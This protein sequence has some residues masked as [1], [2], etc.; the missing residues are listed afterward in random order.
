MSRT[1]CPWRSSSACI[2]PAGNPRCVQTQAGKSPDFP[3][4]RPIRGEAARPWPRRQWPPCVPTVHPP[5][6]SRSIP[7]WRAL[8]LPIPIQGEEG[9]TGTRYP[10]A[11]RPTTKV[12]PKRARFRGA[13]TY[14]IYDF[15]TV[16][17]HSPRRSQDAL[18]AVAMIPARGGSK[19]LP[20]KRPALLRQAPD[21]LD[22][23]KR[24]RCR[25]RR[26]GGG[27]DRR[28]GNRRSEP[29]IRRRGGPPAAGAQRRSF[30]FRKALLHALDSW[31]STSG[32]WPFSSAPRP[33]TL[34][35]DIDGT[36]GL[37]PRRIPPS[38]PHRGAASSGKTRWGA[39]PVGHDKEAP[40]AE[41][42]RAPVRRGPGAVYAMKVEGLRPSGGVS[43]APPPSSCPLNGASK[44]T[45]K[46]TSH[47]RQ[48]L[49]RRRLRG[50]KAGGCH[51]GRRRRGDGLRR[52]LHR[53]PRD[54]DQHGVESVACHRGDGWAI[55]A[56]RNAGSNSGADQ[57]VQ[58]RGPAPVQKLGVQCLVAH[59]KLTALKAGSQ[60]HDPGVSRLRGER[61]TGLTVACSYAGCGSR[62]R[63]TPSTAK[64]A[65]ACASRRPA[66]RGAIREWQMLIFTS[67][68][69]RVN[70][71]HHR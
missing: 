8:P 71:P 37:G 60:R 12:R 28:S 64:A 18:K 29:E 3:R 69:E 33:L 20:A 70:D 10:R 66:G 1:N 48:T 23:R 44:L 25:L 7:I 15:H 5:T 68:R 42:L 19:G 50:A 62:P 14:P 16:T 43:T 41:E 67:R 53:Q 36:L 9:R 56:L 39:R 30:P 49:L 26:T 46:P 17:T 45:T 47:R 2:K 11:C 54:V 24:P 40:D 6:F 35:E 27:L 65:A 57:R 22:H 58:S 4:I 34:P 52:R 51:R 38:P 13:Q 31:G 21:R 55:G 32:P 61:R 59:E 63:R